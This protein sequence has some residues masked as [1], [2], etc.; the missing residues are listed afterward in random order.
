M[1]GQQNGPSDQAAEDAYC[2]QNSQKSEEQ[3]AIERGMMKDVVVLNFEER[4]KPVD[5]T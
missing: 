4:A 1:N 3:I 5:P 2:A